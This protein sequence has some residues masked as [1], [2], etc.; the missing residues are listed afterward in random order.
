MMDI[1][2]RTNFE[3]DWKLITIFIGGN[4]LCALDRSEDA[5]PENYVAFI[6]ET[7]DYLQKEVSF[8]FLN[9]SNQLLVH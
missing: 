1:F 5:Q 6:R 3:N 4:D 8:M 9:H 7:L 2:Q